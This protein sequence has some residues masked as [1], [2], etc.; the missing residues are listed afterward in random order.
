MLPTIAGMSTS[1]LSSSRWGLTTYTDCENSRSPL[2]LIM[3][4]H[5]SR[6]TN[7]SSKV[8]AL[9]SLRANQAFQKFLTYPNLADTSAPELAR[10]S[11]MAY[12]P[13][14]PRWI[15]HAASARCA[16]SP[17]HAKQDHSFALTRLKTL[18]HCTAGG[19][20]HRIQ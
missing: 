5:Q 17:R 3:H 10:R 11:Y 15:H 7:L 18:Q 2:R 12:A 9:S 8:C 14:Q 4:V 13:G 19:R 6:V 20:L 1:W 16:R